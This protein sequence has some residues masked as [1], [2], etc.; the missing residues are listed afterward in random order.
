MSTVQFEMIDD[1]IGKLTLNRPEAANAFSKQL[2][3]DFN[4]QLDSIEKHETLRALIITANGE[5]AFC[6][7]ADLKERRTM[8]QDQVVDAVGQISSLVTR[9][10]NLK[11]PTIAAINGATF[12]GGL[13]LTLGCDIRI[14]STNAKM[15]LTETSLAII[16]G[17]GGTQRLARLI[18][19]AKA[20]YY[21]LTAKRF[22]SYEGERI[23]LIEKVVELSELQDEALQ[24]ASQIASNGPVGVQMAKQAIDE[25]LDHD[26]ETGLKLEREKYLNTI[27]TKDRL[28][29][30]EAFKEKRK[31]IFT[32]K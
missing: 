32:G 15:G 1:Y 19:L 29:A 28:E 21:I 23:G 5:K 12:G 27:P 26:I 4:E 30:L 13:E 7:G 24:I 20:K 10:A 17:A 18:G 8:T 3:H 31:P 11:V 2:M 14:A 25:G 16:P 9:V 6:A 22:D